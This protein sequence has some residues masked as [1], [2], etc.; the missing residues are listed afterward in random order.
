MVQGRNDKFWPKRNFG[1]EHIILSF[2]K[3]ND[4]KVMAVEI[5]IFNCKLTHNTWW[6]CIYMYSVLLHLYLPGLPSGVHPA[7]HVDG[8]APDVVQR[9]TSSYYTSHHWTVVQT[10]TNTRNGIKTRPYTCNRL[11][12][13]ICKKWSI[14]GTDIRVQMRCP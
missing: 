14:I 4:T 12:I 10:C 7:G 1:L 11:P 6:Y 9:F 3:I 13:L 5:I 8:V 2:Q